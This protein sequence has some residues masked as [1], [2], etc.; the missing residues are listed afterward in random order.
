VWPENDASHLYV[1]FFAYHCRA[2]ARFMIPQK[3]GRIINIG[4]IA[5]D[6]MQMARSTS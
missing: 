3:S 4:S 5:G 2:A 1:F 6:V